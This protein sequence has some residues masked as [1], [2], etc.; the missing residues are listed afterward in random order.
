MTQKDNSEIWRKLVN[1]LNNIEAPA[2]IGVNDEFGNG[3]SYAPLDEVIRV[4]KQALSKENLAFIQIPD[5]SIDNVNG[6][7]V[8][9]VKVVTRIVDES[10]DYVDFPPVT[11]TTTSNPHAIGSAMTYARRYSLNSL[12]GVASEEDDDGN[13]SEGR[14]V[15]N[16]PQ[17]QQQ[18]QQVQQPTNEQDV[19]L[20]T[21]VQESRLKGKIKDLA[22]LR[23]VSENMVAESLGVSHI[24]NLHK[25]RKQKYELENNTINKWLEQDHQIRDKKGEGEV[26]ML[27]DILKIMDEYH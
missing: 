20:I 1:V 13:M 6:T 9:V 12:L 25:V 4:V 8:T 3:F 7:H 16:Q 27:P 19:K 14:G 17:T 10:G 5:V 22:S 23:G 24:T 2:K 26:D 18:P 21:S 15:G 11:M